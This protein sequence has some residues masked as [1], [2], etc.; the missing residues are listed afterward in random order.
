MASL[1]ER[2]R[3]KPAHNTEIKSAKLERLRS[4][5]LIRPDPKATNSRHAKAT[6][7]IMD[8]SLLGPTINHF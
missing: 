2:E 6:S 4:A 5:R 8:S 7:E 1:E 3:E